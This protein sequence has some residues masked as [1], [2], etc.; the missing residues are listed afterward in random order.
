MWNAERQR[1]E[2]VLQMTYDGLAIDEQRDV[3]GA[4]RAGRRRRRSCSRSRR[5]PPAS[6]ASSTRLALASGARAIVVRREAR[7]GAGLVAPTDDALADV[8]AARARRP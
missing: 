3:E 1:V 4:R 2:R 6:S 5:S 7:A 8:I